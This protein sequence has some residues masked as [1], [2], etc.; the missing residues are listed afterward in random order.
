MLTDTPTLT[1]THKVIIGIS[2]A[3][4]VIGVLLLTYFKLVLLINCLYQMC[5]RK[6]TKKAIKI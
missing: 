1:K 6:I 3:I 5:F 2:S 4:L